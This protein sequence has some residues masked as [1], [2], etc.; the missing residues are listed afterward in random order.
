MKITALE[1]IRIAE[2]ANVLWLKVHTS[3]GIVGLGETFSFRRPSRLT[4]TKTSRRSC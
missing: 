2:F 3:E 1:T 4:S